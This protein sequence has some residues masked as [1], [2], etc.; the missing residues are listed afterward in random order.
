MRIFDYFQICLFLV[1]QLGLF[2]FL[3]IILETSFNNSCSYFKSHKQNIRMTYKETSLIISRKFCTFLTPR[4][5]SRA[6]LTTFKSHLFQGVSKSIMAYGYGIM[7]FPTHV[8]P[9]IEYKSIW[10]AL[11]IF[12][13][14]LVRIYVNLASLSFMEIR[15]LLMHEI[16][17]I[18]L[19]LW[20]KK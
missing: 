9:S 7:S 18:F 3:F 11:S 1:Y 8:H 14:A 12:N 13:G 19:E 15:C 17:P 10:V 20:G 16:W 4:H 2:G 6:C 5:N